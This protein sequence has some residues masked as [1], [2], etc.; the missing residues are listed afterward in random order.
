MRKLLLITVILL[1]I[2]ESESIFAQSNPTLQETELWLN[3]YANTLLS[4]KWESKSGN[5]RVI[6]SFNIKDGYINFWRD[7]EENIDKLWRVKKTIHYKLDIAKASLIYTKPASQSEPT[8]ITILGIFKSVAISDFSFEMG[9]SYAYKPSVTIDEE[10]SLFMGVKDNESAK[11]IL[12][13]LTNLI[14]LRKLNVEIMNTLEIEN[15]F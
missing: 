5:E 9:K 2:I 8:R 3:T 10:F 14:K 13:A 1:S 7:Y 15:K 11:R 4:N 6:Q 12:K